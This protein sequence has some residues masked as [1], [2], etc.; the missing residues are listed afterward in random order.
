MIQASDGSITHFIEDLK[1]GDKAAAAPLWQ[2]YFPRL[3]GLAQKKLRG[4]RRSADADEEDAVI[5]AF[6]S[7]CD[8]AAKGRFPNL[9]DRDDLWRLLLVITVRKVWDQLKRGQAA[10]RGGSRVWLEAD[11]RVGDEDGLLDQV[12]GREPSPEFAMMLAEGFEGLLSQLDHEL[13]RVALL[14]LEGDTD[15]EIAAKLGFCRRTVSF[16]L[17]LIRR[18]WREAE[19]NERDR[20]G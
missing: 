9:R 8:G 2:R 3:M 14:K 7:F 17:A 10:E 13:R 16:K 19:R 20:A 1:A 4:A 15:Q 6:D 11:L 12:V 18:I 5:S